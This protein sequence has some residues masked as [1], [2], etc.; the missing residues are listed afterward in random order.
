LFFVFAALANT[1]LPRSI[2]PP[3]HFS[4][5]AAVG[6]TAT[7]IPVGTESR[8]WTLKEVGWRPLR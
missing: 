7:F 2:P 8:A 1:C 6:L 5:S 4:H 3:E